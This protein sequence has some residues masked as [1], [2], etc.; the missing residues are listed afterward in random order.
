LKA[1]WAGRVIAWVVSA[2]FAMSAVMKLLALPMVVEGTTHLGLPLSLIR[3]LG[4]LELACV[5]VYLVP[6]TAVF[7][8]I[9][10]TGFVGGTIVTHLRVG[11]PPVAQ[12]L[13]GVLFWIALYLRKPRLRELI[14]AA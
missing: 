12:I 8:T 11:E 2:L 13:C 10:L 5:A 3:P 4:V 1:I 14:W 7:G 6:Q 9:L